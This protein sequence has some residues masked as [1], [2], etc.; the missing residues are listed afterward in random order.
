MTLQ[1][2]M[3]FAARLETIDIKCDLPELELPTINRHL[4]STRGSS[5]ISLENDL[6]INLAKI[7][8]ADMKI[9]TP[10]QIEKELGAIEKGES[11]PWGALSL[12]L[13]SI[14]NTGYWHRD[15]DSFTGWLEKN[16]FRFGVNPPMLWRILAAGRFVCQIRDRLVD[17]GIAVPELQD[18]P[19]NVSPESVEL[20]AK[21]ERVIPE[22][23]F[24]GLAH[25]VFS[26]QA[27]RAELRS[28][29]QTYRPALGGQTARGRGVSIPRLNPKDPDQYNSLMEAMVLDALKAA[30]P[31]WSGHKMP[32]IYQVLLHVNPS[33]YRDLPGNYLFS[34]VV[35][36]K[37]MK[38]DI[39]YHGFRYRPFAITGPRV[40]EF[41]ETAYCD[42]LW[43]MTPPRP[44]AGISPLKNEIELPDFIGL[45]ELKDGKVNVLKPAKRIPNSGELREQLTIAL[46]ARSLGGK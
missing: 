29:W 38:G 21:I 46:L 43:F 25:K 34:A 35:V 6:T 12:L 22:D 10:K 2:R 8:L 39:E 23:A 44:F 7:T 40:K 28:T 30:G 3:F 5:Y 31:V 11:R 13:D 4:L 27:T 20:L 33:G 14:E 45:V 15:S 16:A 42:F 18:V 37:P 32:S 1:L 9:N 41:R 24:P 17:K 19:D 26:G 36:I